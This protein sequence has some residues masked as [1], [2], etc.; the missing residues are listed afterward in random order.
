MGRR[1]ATLAELQTIYSLED[2]YLMYEVI[3]VNNHN[4]R[5]TLKGKPNGHNH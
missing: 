1:M 2:A 5:Q 4:E 3:L